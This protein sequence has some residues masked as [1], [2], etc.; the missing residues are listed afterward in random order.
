MSASLFVLESLHGVNVSSHECLLAVSVHGSLFLCIVL[1]LHEF[2]WCE[3][4]SRG[5][6]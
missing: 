5:F 4:P 3:Y 1:S 2:A 6:S